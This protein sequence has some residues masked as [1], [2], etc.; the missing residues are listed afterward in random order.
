MSSTV[1]APSFHVKHQCRRV[2]F[3]PHTLQHLLFVE[4]LPMD[5]LTGVRCM[6]F[7]FAFLS[8]LVTLTFFLCDLL[9]QYELNLLIQI[10]FLNACPVLIICLMTSPRTFLE[11]RCF[12]LTALQA[13]WILSVHEQWFQS[14][15]YKNGHRAPACFYAQLWL[16]GE[17]DP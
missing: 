6:K 9:K 15:Y 4:F 13:L 3:S 7:W 12:L 10:G 11:G 16:L 5:F 1:A 14:C 2:L 17:P 8:Y